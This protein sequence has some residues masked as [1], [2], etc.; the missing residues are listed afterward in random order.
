MKTAQLATLY[1]ICLLAILPVAASA[2]PYTVSADGSEVTDQE[3]G[4]IW[5]RCAEG[6][7]FSGGTCTGTAGKFTHEAALQQAATQASSTGIAWRLPSIKELSSIA[8]KKSSPT[9]RAA[10]PATPVGLF[11]SATPGAGNSAG[12]WRAAFYNGNVTTRHQNNIYH[13]RLVRTSQ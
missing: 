12:I 10:F 2:K 5:R 13:V 8:D 3:T 11:W 6:M 1:F 9:R 4:L 7:V